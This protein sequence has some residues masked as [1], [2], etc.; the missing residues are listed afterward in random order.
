MNENKQK[1]VKLLDNK[2]FDKKA[3]ETQSLEDLIRL[4]E[5]YG[6][7]LTASETEELKEHF[8]PNTELDETALESVAG[9]RKYNYNPWSWK[10]FKD[11]IRGVWAGL[12]E[13]W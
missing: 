7:S 1:I 4:F 13:K 6:V 10:N 9:G 3:Q 5:E 12:T 11:Y 8:A 2:E